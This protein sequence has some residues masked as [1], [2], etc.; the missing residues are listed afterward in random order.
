VIAAAIALWPKAPGPAPG[1][2]PSHVTV[3]FITHPFEATIFLDGVL[4]QT[5]DGK[6]YLTPCTVPDLTAQRHHVTFRHPTLG[7][8]DAGEFEFARTREIEASWD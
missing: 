8:L 6:P 5:T 2:G 4:L 3:N 7:E 1:S